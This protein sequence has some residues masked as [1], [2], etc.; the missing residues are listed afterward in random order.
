MGLI[1][2]ATAFA[3][4]NLKIGGSFVAKAFQGGAT[5]QVLLSLKL[6]FATVKHMKPKASRADSSEIYIVA[7]GFKG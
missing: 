5:D 2:E 6:R 1:E 7:V 4:D 3:F